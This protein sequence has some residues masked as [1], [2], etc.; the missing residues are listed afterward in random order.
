[1]PTLPCSQGIVAAGRGVEHRP[2]SPRPKARTPAGR[3]TAGIEPDITW[4]AGVTLGGSR[5][6]SFA[7]LEITDADALLEGLGP[8]QR[9]KAESNRLVRPPRLLVPN[10]ALDAPLPDIVAAIRSALEKRP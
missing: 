10:G 9:R 2:R 5:L 3:R 8:E 6:Q 1:M 4:I 7:C